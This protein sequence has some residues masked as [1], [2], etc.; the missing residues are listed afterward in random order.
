MSEPRNPPIGTV[1]FDW[2]GRD[3]VHVAIVPTVAS[4]KLFP[5][6]HVGADGARSI[7]GAVGIVDPYL[8][9]PVEKGQTFFLFLYPGSVT[10]LRHVW[11]HPAFKEAR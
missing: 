7:A 8:R 11:T 3:A 1:D 5:G 6:Q 10:S 9:H 2:T 4:E